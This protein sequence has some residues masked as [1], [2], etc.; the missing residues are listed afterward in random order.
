MFRL[1]LARSVRSSRAVV[2][3]LS[4]APPPAAKPADNLVDVTID[5]VKV[6]VEPG[7][8]VLQVRY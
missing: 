6:R 2:R 1:A 4:T 3:A 8:T 7:T 5:G